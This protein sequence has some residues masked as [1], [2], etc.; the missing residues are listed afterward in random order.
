[1]K[2]TIII[3]IIICIVI[4]IFCVGQNNNSEHFDN[5][6]NRLTDTQCGAACTLIDGCA[7]FAYDSNTNTCWISKTPILTRPIDGVYMADY[8]NLYKRCN[9]S[10]L[11]D[12]IV[13]ANQ[14][15]YNQNATYNCT[16]NNT[17]KS[18][19]VY[20]TTFHTTVNKLSDVTDGVRNGTIKI[21]EPIIQY[22]DWPFS[23]VES[24][25]LELEDVKNFVNPTT[26][27]IIV[28]RELNDEYLGQYMY[29][30]RCVANINKKDCLKDCINNQSCVGTEWNPYYINTTS[31]K[32]NDGT[33]YHNVCCPKIHITKTI[34]R[35][36]EFENGKFYSKEQ[37]LD[38]DIGTFVKNNNIV[39]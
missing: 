27:P 22:F 30:H 7:G 12:D 4:Y 16:T 6:I 38:T 25:P 29:Q 2:I 35:R 11:L 13:T 24:A 14:D 18:I 1:M 39:I 23:I 32:N 33:V 31:N 3:T 21:S 8:N 10:R 34:T 37:I 5:K 36:P 9:K 28:M 19:Q 15:D 20:D 26:K 17:D